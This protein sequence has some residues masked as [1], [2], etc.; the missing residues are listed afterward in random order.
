MRENGGNKNGAG[1][2][3]WRYIRITIDFNSSLNILIKSLTL[4]FISSNLCT[5]YDKY[6]AKFIACV[7]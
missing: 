4:A 2:R 3:G 5:V 7:Q 6:S 1:I